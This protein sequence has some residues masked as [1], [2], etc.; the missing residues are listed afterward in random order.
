MLVAF[1]NQDAKQM[2][3]VAGSMREAFG[4]QKNVR[5]SGIVE[6]EGLPT[7]TKIKNAAH[8]E[9]EDS[10][11]TPTADEQGSSFKHDQVFSLAAAS[12]RQALRD[13]PELTEASKHIMIEETKEG[14]NIDIVDQDGRS[15]FP[16]GSKEPNER[17]RNLIQKIAGPLKAVPYRI[18]ITGH[19]SG[20]RTSSESNHRPWTLSADRANAI[21]QILEEEGYPSANIYKIAGKA[22]TDPL[23]PDDPSTAPNRRVTITLMREAPPVPPDLKP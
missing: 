10:S 19:T 16:E 5:Y 20:S 22:D 8:I 15:M 12:L 7:R 14:L 4:V 11:I 6:S 23:F 21:R 3:A 17:A 1:S 2:K 13:M 18:S 9:P